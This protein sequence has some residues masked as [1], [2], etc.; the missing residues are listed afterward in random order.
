MS[1]KWKT[2]LF[3][4]TILALGFLYLF[5][6]SPIFNTT[7][8]L[9]VGLYE[10]TTHPAD[11]VL[12][13]LNPAQQAEAQKHD[14]AGRGICPDHSQPLLKRVLH[15][16]R[17]LALTSEGFVA[18]GRPI[19]N[20][21]PKPLDS[22]GRRLVHYPFAEYRPDPKTMWVFSD[23]DA[24]SYDSRYYGPLDRRQI[25]RYATPTPFLFSR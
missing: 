2:Q 6:Q 15:F 7:S 23:Y 16:D 1:R 21:R 8:S 5:R 14:I 19:P 12:V 24:R 20:T 11:Y 3:C 25:L 17:A 18:D 4:L 22:K 10:M 13:C 9:P